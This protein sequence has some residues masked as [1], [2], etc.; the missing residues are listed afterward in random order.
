MFT[1]LRR[2]RD[3]RPT[4][5][6]VRSSTP[7]GGWEETTWAE[8]YAAAESAAARASRDTGDAPV[9]V[10]VDGTAAS[11]ATVLGILGVGRDVLLLEEQTSYL[12]DTGSPVHAVGASTVVGPPAAVEGT[13]YLAYEDYR[14]PA[15]PGLTVDGPP[16]E[17]L[18]LTSGSTGEPRITRQPLDNVLWGGRVYDKLFEL[19]GDDV[20]VV[21]V[22]LAHSYGLAGLFCAVLCGATL[23]T[24]P[25]FSIRS[26][27]SALDGGATALLGTP[28]LYRLIAPVLAA[29]RRTRKVRMALSAGGPVPDKVATDIAEALGAPIRQIYGITEAGL[30]T[31]VPQSVPSWPVGTAGFAAPG[32]T[33]RVDTSWTGAD[34]TGIPGGG[35]TGRLFVRTPTMFTGYWGR[36]DSVLTEDGYYDT[37]DLV[38]L[39]PS[40]HL[41][42]LGRRDNF[43]NVG[44]RKVNPQ[45]IERILSGHPG[46]REA[47]VYGGD[48]AD[49]EEEIHA[50]VVLDAA[51]DTDELVEYCRSRSLMPYEV[52]HRI[53]R[54]DRLPRTGMGKVDR[55]AVLAAVER[56]PDLVRTETTSRG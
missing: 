54:L 56:I 21:A 44:G 28:L 2:I 6:A 7:E 35:E 10:L 50:A 3:S 55:Q 26:L 51:T 52:P 40:G 13:A 15:D 8:L 33:L 41:F 14:A 43:I 29:R 49:Q 16:G 20:I 48:R 18:Q 47:F 23:V 22:P 19:N 53:H 38:R 36:S 5:P 46:V 30:V 17:V 9:V 31:C 39:D 25:R 45:R 4:S 24:L 32:V 27:V 34:A 37:G 42:V 12:S 11:V 1:E